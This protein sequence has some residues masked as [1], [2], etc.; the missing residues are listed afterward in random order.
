MTG[1]ELVVAGWFAVNVISKLADQVVSLVKKQ[2]KYQKG[3]KR[4]LKTLA[5]DLKK[6][7]AAIYSACRLQI[8]NPALQHWML[9]LMD[10]AKAAENV[11]NKFSCNVAGEREEPARPRGFTKSTGTI[12]KRLFFHD[13]YLDELNDVLN[14]F[15]KVA[16]EMGN[17]LKLVELDLVVRK[18]REMLGGQQ[19][20]SMPIESNVV[21]RDNE[22]ND[23]VNFLLATGNSYVCGNDV[24]FAVVSIVGIHGVGKTT[25]ARC[26]Y[27]DRNIQ[28]HFDIKVWLCV[29]DEFNVKRLMI[30]IIESACIQRPHDLHRLINLDTIQGILNQV[31]MEKKFL[32][33][34]DGI[35]S[36]QIIAGWE[37][38]WPSFKFGKKGSRIILTTCDQN[39]GEMMEMKTINLKGIEGQD[40][41]R[42]FEQWAS[43]GVNPRDLPILKSVVKQIAPK[44]GGSPLAAKMVGLK[45]ASMLRE[46]GQKIMQSKL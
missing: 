44:L 43:R 28:G 16:A 14:R 17:F 36:D 13:R 40:Y 21:G 27:N 33:V 8:T 24:N 26:V 32:V 46:Q 18:H 1:L 45:I 35:R 30:E 10:A 5:E 7:Q 37:T 42:L 23:M 39:I 3:V 11:L 22:R 12:V 2:I 15:G 19:T 20:T 34:F 29:S 9:E 4:K 41:W 31:L 6:I 38:L 25:L